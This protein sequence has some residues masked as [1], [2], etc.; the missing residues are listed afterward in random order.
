MKSN[1]KFGVGLFV[2]LFIN[3]SG[4]YAQKL[5]VNG[6]FLLGLP[7]GEFSDNVKNTG[8]G[9]GGYFAYPIGETPLMAGL[10]IGVIH[11]GEDI[12]EALKNDSLNVKARVEPIDNL[13]TIHA[14]LRIQSRTW[15]IRPYA[16]LL[17]GLHHFFQ[18]QRRPSHSRQVILFL[19]PF[20]LIKLVVHLVLA[21][22]AGS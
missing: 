16:E 19:L 2:L 6:N 11:Y 4:I 12:P 18:K 13:L 17:V 1:Y 10:D 9:F 3:P 8:Y 5:H 20:P 7:Q 15:P 21:L 22:A 14:L